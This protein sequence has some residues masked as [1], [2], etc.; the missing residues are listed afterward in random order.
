MKKIY[1]FDVMFDKDAATKYIAY[2]D[3]QWVSYDDAETLKMK[4]DFA[5]QVGYALYG[6]IF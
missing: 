4:V 3:N 2:D 5:N 6:L 1:Q